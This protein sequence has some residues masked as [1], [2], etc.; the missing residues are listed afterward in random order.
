LFV[1][2][3][4]GTVREPEGARRCAEIGYFSTSKHNEL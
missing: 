3:F 2:A 1:A 4:T